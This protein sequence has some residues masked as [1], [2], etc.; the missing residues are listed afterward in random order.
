MLETGMKEFLKQTLY[1]KKLA[2][3]LAPIFSTYNYFDLCRAVFCINAWRSN[4]VQLQFGL[5]LNYA[6]TVC[7]RKGE[8][9]LQTYSEFTQ[10]FNK[11]KQFF[12]DT[13]YDN[14][15]P[16]FG[17]IKVAYNEKFYPVFLGTG[18]NFVFP[19]MQSMYPIARKFDFVS[20]LEE[21]L[22]YVQDMVR[23][24]GVANPYDENS[25]LTQL[26]LPKKSFFDACKKWYRVR[27][28]S[29]SSVLNGLTNEKKSEIE[30]A[31]FVVVKNGTYALFNAGI[32][33]DAFQLLFLN[34]NLTKTQVCEAANLA[35]Y[36]A[37]QSNIVLNPDSKNLM[38]NV[39][40]VEDLPTQKI[41]QQLLFNFA[42]VGERS[43]VL[44]LNEDN[45]EKR[46]IKKL[47]KQINSLVK[48]KQLK[49]AE[50]T[51]SNR[52][53][54]YDFSPIENAVVVVYDNHLMLDYAMKAFE[55]NEAIHYFV[56]DIIALLY[57]TRHVKDVCEFFTKLY[58]GQIINF[59][60]WG[61]AGLYEAWLKQNK[62]FS[63]GAVEINAVYAGVYV[64]E[65]SLFEEYRTLAAWYPF[66]KYT[67]TF[68]N[69]CRWIAD[70]RSEKGFV[71][72]TNKAARDLGGYFRKVASSYLFLTHNATLLD[73]D[74]GVHQ[75]IEIIRMIEEVCMH[76]FVTH[77]KSLRENGLYN[78]TGVHVLYIPTK[79]ARDNFGD[80][81]FDPSRKY[82]YS[83]AR[84][85]QDRILIRFAV[86]EQ[87]LFDD[88][89]ASEDKSVECDFLK[90]L[91]LCVQDFPSVNYAEISKAIDSARTD[92]KD[93]EAMKIEIKCFM[94]DKNIGIKLDDKHYINVRKKI[95]YDCKK[96]NVKSGVYT[97][98]QATKTIRAIQ[99]IVIPHF[100]EAIAQYDRIELH[101]A[102]LS[103][104][105][106]NIHNKNIN[107]QRY[108]L[109][110]KSNLSADA[111]QTTGANTLNSRE[112]NKETIR[113]LLYIIDTNLAIEHTAKATK[114][115]DDNLKE[116]IAYS[117]WL[118]VLQDCA[119]QAHYNLFETKVQIEEDYRVSTVHNDE[120]SEL[121]LRRNKRFY[122]NVDYRPLLEKDEEMVRQVKECFYN[123][124]KVS[125]DCIWLVC[126]Y[127]YREFYHTFQQE[128]CPDVFEIP[129]AA[130][131]EDII[132]WLEGVGEEKL[133][134]VFDALD[135]L[136]AQ[137]DRIKDLKGKKEQFVPLW[138][139]EGRDYR[140]E[141]RPIVKHND[142]LIFSPAVM[143]E[144][145]TMW[146][147]G[148]VQFYP[149]YEYGL[150]STMT[151]LKEWK[152][153]CEKKM[154]EDIANKFKALGLDTR[155]DL[156]L[157]KLDKSYGHPEE[158]GDYDIVAVDTVNK[159]VWNIECKFLIMVG[160]TREY[161]NH[162]YT[163]FISDKK[164]EKFLARIKYLEKHLQPILKA[165]N[166]QDT[167]GYTVQSY[168]V[169]NKVFN[170]DIKR[171]DFD[172]ITY[173]ELMNM[174]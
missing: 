51:D 54:V 117:H 78:C 111:Q 66:E 98:E 154:E 144:L 129:Q 74:D 139:R 58:S 60:F 29:N 57:R 124:T 137:G 145:S 55:R 166:V 11:I 45:I 79:Y 18:H 100:E 9:R 48:N 158:L 89:M 162:Q 121:A 49:I 104:L 110:Q 151:K 148:I 135:Y 83:D 108:A 165:L 150:D 164:D 69:P 25:S 4:K 41:A 90:E 85:E 134:G 93:I 172:I 16:D 43:L 37:L 23:A 86:N 47:E 61:I 126:S 168:M 118:V 17:D 6:L 160:S 63:Q 65:W 136:I 42:I 161:Y 52:V 107:F 24:L 22:V 125:L 173:H 31:H 142:M 73:F 77:E 119:D 133:Q 153:L 5:T 36:D 75:R 120:Q 2:G 106:Y 169:T 159:R 32:I 95:A 99:Q 103:E 27:K 143:Y 149:P 88:I 127:F 64:L 128:A 170:A 39:G 80:A 50:F 141:V 28:L 34:C 14:I 152:A 132:S 82:V 114:L 72:L 35:M 56:Y 109:I 62:E 156:K 138:H 101:K 59:D 116:L 38:L 146:Q 33:V 21:V 1:D 84:I 94:S 140:F 40:V 30:E 105:A 163:F 81:F 10:F 131:K 53:N 174:L 97:A 122:D 71:T 157:H 96:A 44:L 171:V 67:Y 102:L 19:M 147:S 130:V 76:N 70:Y 20:Q 3:T 68:D 8:K 115:T 91:L 112:R 26:H 113:D 12:V 46:D 167:D 15:L 7:E 92:K 87:Q 155:K 123:D 13:N